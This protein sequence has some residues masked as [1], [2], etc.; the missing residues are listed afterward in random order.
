[1]RIKL[2]LRRPVGLAITPRF[3]C[4]DLI[5]VFVFSTPILGF[6]PQMTLAFISGIRFC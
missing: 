1:M 3:P 2:P 6:R 4:E 5:L